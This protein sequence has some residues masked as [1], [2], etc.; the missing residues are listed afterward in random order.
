MYYHPPAQAIINA[1]PID[2]PLILRAQPHNEHDRNAIGV[3]V[4]SSVFADLDPEPIEQQ[5]ATSGIGIKDILSQD[6]WFLGYI[7]RPI[8]AKLKASKTVTD[9]ADVEGWFGCKPDGS[10][11]VNF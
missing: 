3:L 1:L 8:A 2:A 6:E 7:P 5:L 4:S 11:E 9:S 10:P